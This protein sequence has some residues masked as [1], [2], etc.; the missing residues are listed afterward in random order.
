MEVPIH[1]QPVLVPAVAVPLAPEPPQPALDA[2]VVTNAAVQLQA[3]GT[4]T[5]ALPGPSGG[6]RGTG[7]GPGRGPGVGP[8][9][10]G[11]TG[12]GPRALGAGITPPVPI[13]QAKPSYTAAA[14]QAKIAGEVLLEIV[15]RADG[16]VGSARILR[17]LDRRYGLD[18]EAIRTA[19]L[20][21]FSPA[22]AGGKPIDVFVQLALEFRIY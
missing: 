17:S 21:R 18:E 6:G 10:D 13:Y 3:S 8:G 2:P 22:T 19:K 15:V 16:T 5:I 20:W 9:S 1:T 11:G 14:M 7:L 12:G 4:A